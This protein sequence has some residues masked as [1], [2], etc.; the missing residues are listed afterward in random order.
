M[1]DASNAR[2]PCSQTPCRSSAKLGGPRRWSSNRARRL[3][4][5]MFLIQMGT[6][7]SRS[8]ACTTRATS[9]GRCSQSPA[10]RPRFR[11]SPSAR[12]RERAVEANDVFSYFAPSAVA[13]TNTPTSAPFSFINQFWSNLPQVS[14]TWCSMSTTSLR[15]SSL[16]PLTHSIHF[17]CLPSPILLR[18]S[19]SSRAIFH[20]S[21]FSCPGMIRGG[22]AR[23]NQSR[24]PTKCGF[25]GKTL[26]WFLHPHPVP[27]APEDMLVL[28]PWLPGS[29]SRA[30]CLPPISHP[31]LLLMPP[32]PIPVGPP[33]GAA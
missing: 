14:S 2:S 16:Q 27:P 9:S 7:I 17:A 5:R 28:K 24:L 31:R 25:A 26:L 30:S 11:N 8:T 29:S 10:K 18:H 15:T 33:G 3:P 12:C 13:Y 20:T 4:P 23:Y 19:L 6:R 1:A 21:I 32:N 22:N